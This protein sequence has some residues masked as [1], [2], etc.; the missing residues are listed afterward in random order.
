MRTH[1]LRHRALRAERPVRAQHGQLA[2]RQHRRPYRRRTGK[3]WSQQAELTAANGAGGDRFGGA[4][5]ISGKTALVGPRE[6]DAST[7][8]AYVFVRSGG[9]GHSS[10]R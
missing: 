1:L 7:G 4:V 5:A 6:K 3:T 2:H 10:R 9:P 8:A